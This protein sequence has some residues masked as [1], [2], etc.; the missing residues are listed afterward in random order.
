MPL[1]LEMHLFIIIIIFFLLP[2][3]TCIL[4]GQ[5]LQIGG[6]Q[7]NPEAITLYQTEIIYSFTD[8]LTLCLGLNQI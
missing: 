3:L 1:C 2:V 8:H 4:F 7:N 5:I 6:T